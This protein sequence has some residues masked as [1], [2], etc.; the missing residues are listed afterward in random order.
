MPIRFNNVNYGKLSEVLRRTNLSAATHLRQ[1]SSGSRITTAADDPA[2]M[3]ISSKIRASIRSYNQALRNVNDGLSLLSVAESS[4]A[5]VGEQLIRMRELA[6]QAASS[7]IGTSERDSLQEEFATLQQEITRVADSTAFNGVNLL[8]GTLSTGSGGL[9]I[10]AGIN[11]GTVD[12]INV[13]VDSVLLA[14]L[15]IDS[16]T[17]ATVTDAGNA[18]GELDTA[19]SYAALA[20]GKVGAGMNEMMATIHNLAASVE[21]S[22]A[23][24]SRIQDADVARTAALLATEMVLLQGNVAVMAQANVNQAMALQLLA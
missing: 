17:L 22:T 16:S 21:T 10:N 14:D 12:R 19:I 15:G 1:L 18:L 3:I 23:A 6:L 20:R 5:S 9:D 4:M 2:G 8:D 24:N 11:G 7:H 13:T